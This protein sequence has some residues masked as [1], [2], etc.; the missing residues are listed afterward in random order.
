MLTPRDLLD[1]LP[2]NPVILEAG[3]HHGEDTV[4]LA[5][6]A[7]WVYAF[8]P[9]PEL[10]EVTARVTAHCENVTLSRLALGGE[11]AMGWMHVSIGRDDASS[12][13]MAPAQHE[14]YY[15]HIHFKSQPIAVSVSTIRSWSEVNGIYHIDGMWLDMQGSELSALKAAG[16]ILDT[17]TSIMMEISLKE[18]YAGA[19]L[20]PEV[21]QWLHANGYKVVK[22][23]IYPGNYAGEVIATR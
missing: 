20:W 2:A 4:A 11:D 5:C 13:L 22:K 23:F 16:T 19:P 7:A 18:L 14:R 15:P 21:N 17:T 6:N 9:I 1:H 10:Y 8:E 3:A 12:S